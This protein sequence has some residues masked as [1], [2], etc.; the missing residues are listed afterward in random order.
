MSIEI[1]KSIKPVNY[2]DAIDF[3]E[4]RVTKINI[5]DANELIWILE[6]PSI[7]TAGTSFNE[8][9]ILDKSIKVVKTSRGGKITWHGPGQ[10]VCYFVINLNNRKKDIRKFLNIIE[11]SIITSLKKFGISSYSD[12]KNIGIW[13]KINNIEPE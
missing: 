8:N 6:H 2:F 12:R 11:N 1:K 13:T 4:K 9:D 10:L 3:L 5:N 7:F